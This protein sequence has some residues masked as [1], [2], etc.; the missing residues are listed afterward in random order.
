[1]VKFLY[2]IQEENY[3]ICKVGFSKNPNKR[4]RT[5][6]TYSSKNLYLYY[7]EEFDSDKIKHLEK[8]IHDTLK[9]HKIRG[10]WFN[11]DPYSAKL[12]I[13]HIK[14]FY[15]DDFNTKVKFF[16]PHYK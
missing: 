16:G 7:Y 13:E 11:I 8:I 2:I 5:S 12:E 1:M 9:H 6:Q 15:E 3:N 4:V 10:E 14:I